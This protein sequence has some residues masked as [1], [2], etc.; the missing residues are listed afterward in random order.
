VAWQVDLSSVE[1]QRDGIRWDLYARVGAV[2]AARAFVIR[3]CRFSRRP[4]TVDAYARNLERFLAWFEEN[5]ATQWIEADEGVLL[6][7]FDDLRHGRVPGI[8]A[9]LKHALPQN[10]VLAFRFAYR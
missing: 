8:N 3:L 9:G 1:G 2:P 6:T 5:P 7:C 4:K 10:V